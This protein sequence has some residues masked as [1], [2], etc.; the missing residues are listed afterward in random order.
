MYS[1]MQIKIV[2]FGYVKKTNQIFIF[3]KMTQNPEKNHHY[4][5]SNIFIHKYFQVRRRI[6]GSGV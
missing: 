3:G 4:H 2:T 6:T 5:N 1:K